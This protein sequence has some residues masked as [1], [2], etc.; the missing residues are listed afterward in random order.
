MFKYTKR[1]DPGNKNSIVNF[2]AAG[3]GTIFYCLLM[4]FFYVG[5]VNDGSNVTV[6][7][8]TERLGAGDGV[9]LTMNSVAGLVGV[10]FF[11]V[12][13][14]INR[15]I[16]P[17]RTSGIFT[18]VAAIAYI[19]VGNASNV[20]IYTICMCFVTGGIMSAGYIAGGALVASGSPRRRAS[21]W[22]TPPWA[23]TWPPPSMSR[24]SQFWW[25]RWASAAA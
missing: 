23:T 22:A 18:I 3:W 17:R 1:E 7:A 4:F 11:I 20:A 2:G 15:K 10:L 19:G 25:I 16:G 8:V 12:V 6:A 5:F 13:G 24:C 14:Q 9:I 21:S